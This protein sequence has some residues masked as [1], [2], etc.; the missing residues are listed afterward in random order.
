MS[1]LGVSFSLK[2]A[3]EMGVD[4]RK[5]LRSALD[6]LGFTRLR[7]MSYW[8]LHEPERGRYDFTD[9]DWQFALAQK[10]GARVSLAIGLRQPR[11]PESHWPPWARQLPDDE[12]Q[13]ALFDY[14]E[15]VVNR[16]KT[17]PCLESWQL[18]NE[19]LLKSFGTDGDFD[20]SRLKYEFALVKSL[21]PA[22]DVIMTTSDSWG[23]PWHGPIPDRVGISLYRRFYDR[24]RYR[25]SR[26]PPSFYRLRAGLIRLITGRPVFIHELQAEPWGPQA[27]VRLSLEEQR[28]T[29]NAAYI[30]Q[31]F[32][33]ARSTRQL[34]AY[35]WGLEW[36]Y[37][38][39]TT[40]HQ[41]DEWAAVA[42]SLADS[43]ES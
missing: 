7:L 40:H 23:I 12:W 22:H 37:W 6:E 1:D 42:E 38:L 20:R 28:K 29:M 31:A 18:E 30:R 26:R 19:A 9:L 11:W 21:D 33:F 39:K 15:A 34:P 3:R 35:L 24:G 5:C 36:W 4:P 25:R 13:R 16:Y 10:Y 8:D 14:L 2:Y 41:H 43:T 32:T 27:T 17:H